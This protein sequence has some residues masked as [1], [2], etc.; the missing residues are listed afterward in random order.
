MEMAAQVSPRSCPVLPFRSVP[1]LKRRV[2]VGISPSI[3]SQ[4]AFLR[5]SHLCTSH[6]CRSRTPSLLTMRPTLFNRYACNQMIRPI[7]FNRCMC[8]H[9]LCRSSRTFCIR[10]RTRFQVSPRRLL[11]AS[12]HRLTDLT[13]T[14]FS[15]PTSTTL[16]AATISR[17]CQASIMTARAL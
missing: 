16:R 17:P 9:N 5:I 13:T 8:S 1:I 15:H 4:A 3:L 12:L 14:I 7:A 10:S 11:S 6:S 2:T